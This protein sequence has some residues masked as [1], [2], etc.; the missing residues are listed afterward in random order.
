MEAS[1]GNDARAL[2]GHVGADRLGRRRPGTGKY[3]RVIRTVR[4]TSKREAK[5]ALAALETD[6]ASGRLSADDLTV[7][8]LLDRWME[9]LERLGRADTTLYHY[10]KYIDREIKPALGRTKLSKLTALDLD[11]LYTKLGDRGLAPATIRQVHAVLRASLNQAERW[12]LVHRNVAKLASAP[13]Q[14]QREQH[15][16]SAA[17]V[18]TLLAAA[19][20]L[21]PLFGLFIRVMIATGARRAE[22]CGLRWSDVDFENGSLN[23][24]RSYLVIPGALGDRPTKTRSTR[25]VVLDTETLDVPPRRLVGRSNARAGS[26]VADDVRRAGYIFTTDPIGRHRLAARHHQL[27]VGKGPTGRRR[28][29]EPQ[30]ARPAPLPSDAAARCRHPRADGGRTTRARRRNHNDEDLRPP[31]PPRRL[32]RSRDRRWSPHR[33]TRGRPMSPRPTLDGVASE[34]IGRCASAHELAGDQAPTADDVPF[35]RDGRRPQH[36]R[37]AAGVPRRDRR[38][39]ARWQLTATPSSTPIGSS[40]SCTSIVVEY[41]LVGGFL[42]TRAYGAQRRTADVD[43][44]PSTTMENSTASPTH[45]AT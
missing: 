14:P 44:L 28:R 4:T 40:P 18:R 15:P 16:P 33:R 23:I 34:V 39:A 19:N 30:D 22:V 36:A 1:D 31:H 8:A 9:H 42:A 17:D 35:T 41:L 21:S 29:I 5:R 12:G 32:A 24:S 6:V 26:L 7:G 25:T 3:R 37:E 20:E 27:L 45:C 10:R 38:H 2:A 43:C 11:R 13:S